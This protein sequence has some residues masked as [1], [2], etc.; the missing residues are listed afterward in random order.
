MTSR[1]AARWRSASKW[2]FQAPAPLPATRSTSGAKRN[3]LHPLDEEDARARGRLADLARLAVVGRVVEF[4]RRLHRR[5]F[6]HDDAV[7]RAALE[8]LGAAAAHDVLAAVAG[9]RSGGKRPIA[10]IG[11]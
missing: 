2:I 5:E 10:L 1:P 9:D 6:E 4:A 3:A 7:R 11:L 8:R